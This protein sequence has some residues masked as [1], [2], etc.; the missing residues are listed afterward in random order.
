MH[1]ALPEDP[2]DG[3]F[4][5][6]DDVGAFRQG[7]PAS[8]WALARY[9]VGRAIGESVGTTLLLVA[10]V[11]FVLAVM[12]QWPLHLTLL[13]VLLVIAA[14]LVLAV[15]VV[16]LAVL[17]RLTAADRYGPVEDQLR[18]LV[19]DTRSDVLHELRRI[20]L[21]SHLPTLPLLAVRLAGRRRMQ[22][23]TRLRSF[24]ID[25]AVPRS[26]VDELHLLLRQTIRGPGAPG[27]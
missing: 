27:R 25:R 9:L 13:V 17:R 4:L 24:D 15:R 20:G 10:G 26:R 12:A 22:T 6:A 21:P 16:L 2:D 3:V 7:S 1:P 11:L 8:Q 5:S 23:L 14:L 18:S 19:S